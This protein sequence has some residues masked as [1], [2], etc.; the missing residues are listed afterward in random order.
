MDNVSQP[1][2]STSTLGSPFIPAFSICSPVTPTRQNRQ[3]SE[4]GTSVV[5]AASSLI[6]GD[7]PNVDEEEEEEDDEDT[8]KEFG[9]VDLVLDPINYQT[10]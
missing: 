8:V 3:D 1:T 5:R 7:E 2:L 10:S 9:Q 6:Q 4:D